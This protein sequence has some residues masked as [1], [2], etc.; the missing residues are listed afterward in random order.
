MHAK[1]LP[2]RRRHRV[3]DGGFTL[4]EMLVCIGIV[5]V[6]IALLLPAVQQARESGRRV[7][8]ISNLKQIGVGLHGY[9]D[10]YNCLPPG[11]MMTYDSRFAGPNP[12]CTSSMVDKSLFVMILPELEQAA[13][14]SAVNQS[15]TI[16]GYENRSIHR[17]LVNLFV[18]PSD[19][20]ARV[21]QGDAPR[22]AEFGLATSEEVL[23]MAFASYGGCFG[24]FQVWAIPRPE[25]RCMVPSPLAAQADGVFNDLAPISFA[26]IQDGTSA[27]LFVLEKSVTPNRALD[28]VNPAL[29]QRHGWYFTGNIGDTLCTTFFPPNMS[30]RVALGAGASRTYGA[31]SMHPGGLNA[32][33]GD[34]SVRFIRETIETWPFQPMTGQPIA[35]RQTPGGWWDN[36]PSPGVWQKLATRAGGELA[37]GDL[38]Y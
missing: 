16:L 26:S 17:V 2:I 35:A 13:L 9:H 23:P 38:D 11:R 7:S 32:L 12:P 29:F 6:L 34:G 28:A 31:S 37:G 33:M 3:A 1:D 30:G 21:R 5:S 25:K 8:C 15:L 20:E 18:C 27:T 4:V 36:L 19:P 14:Y 10:R 24:S 22:M